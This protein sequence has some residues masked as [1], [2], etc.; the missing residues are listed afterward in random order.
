MDENPV[1]A[2]LPP[3]ENG[4]GLG[5]GLSS[6]VW[7]G[8][9]SCPGTGPST[10]LAVAGGLPE[11]AARC[12]T[13]R[14]LQL[15]DAEP[16]TRHFSDPLVAEYLAPPPGSVPAFERFI[17]WARQ[18]RLAAECCCFGVVPAGAVH[19]AG[20]F[21]LRR[22]N[23][24]GQLAEWGFG[25]GRPHWGTG[26][27]EAC[28]DELLRFAFDRLGVRRLEATVSLGN[29]RGHAVLRRI[30]AVQTGFLACRA[31]EGA[32]LVDGA[33]WSLTP[34]DWQGALGRRRAC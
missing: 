30:G 17:E 8:V 28:A 24:G 16:L 5:S 4:T 13:L 15:C 7:R 23:A 3:R 12:A 9:V 33:V 14:E 25:I 26:I 18:R 27:F 10:W 20:L 34:D 19:A 32:P 2:T 11:L 31:L 22:L 21:Q 1:T 6:G 29:A